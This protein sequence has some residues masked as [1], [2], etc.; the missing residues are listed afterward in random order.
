MKD[1]PDISASCVVVVGIISG[2]KETVSVMDANY[3]ID[4]RKLIITT[5]LASPIAIYSIDGKVI[6]SG[7]VKEIFL[8]DGIYILHLNGKSF[9]LKI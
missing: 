4:N 7:F 3:I 5:D 6:N 1:N 2:I 9:K 8:Q